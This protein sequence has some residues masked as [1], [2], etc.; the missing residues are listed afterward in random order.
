MKRLSLAALAVLLA[1][2]GSDNPPSIAL[3]DSTELVIAADRGATL[4]IDQGIGDVTGKT[5][6]AVSPTVTTTYTLKATALGMSTTSKTT[7]TVG[8]GAASQVT[9]TGLS[10]ELAVDTVAPVT[11]T[12]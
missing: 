10:S 12:V 6:V 4:T 1:A 8:H 9:L 2:C 3:G 11:V 5:S 7:V